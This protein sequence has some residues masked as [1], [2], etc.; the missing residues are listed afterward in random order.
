MKKGENYGKGEGEREIKCILELLSEWKIRKAKEMSD[1]ESIPSG[2]AALLSPAKELTL[3][4]NLDSI[5]FGTQTP[6]LTARH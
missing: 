4:V 2:H 5:L 1:C 6:S 3:R